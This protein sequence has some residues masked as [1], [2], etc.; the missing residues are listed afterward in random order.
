MVHPPALRALY[1]GLTACGVP[2]GA[3]T[4]ADGSDARTRSQPDALLTAWWTALR[5]VRPQPDAA[6]R[7]GR[8]VPA[9]QFAPLDYLANNGATV[10]VALA[11][12]ERDFALMTDALTLERTTLLDGTVE[13]SVRGPEGYPELAAMSA[14][15]LAGVA[16][17]LAR[18]A[19][20]PLTSSALVVPFRA[21]E[22]VGVPVRNEPGRTCFRVG[23]SDLALSLAGAD[24]A[25]LATLE[26]L[27]EDVVRR[28]APDDPLAAVRS[29]LVEAVQRGEPVDIEATARR[30][31]ASRRTLQRRLAA[32]PVTFSAL[33][34]EVRAEHA[35]RLLGRAELS[36][37]EVADA[38]GFSS[39]SPFA[40]AFKRWT[41]LSP[42]AWRQQAR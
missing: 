41:G 3:L 32:V 5:A 14:F 36:V 37:D 1:E 21:A 31:G 35:I 4:A 24:P 16:S 28:D 12:L 13:L 38:L 11:I 39:S 40:R 9:G 29:L 10:G 2:A 17:R 42:R 23:P 6:V 7:V 33:Y 15:I 18:R 30:L 26:R 27:T 20:R 22:R 19:V 34:D 25:L 8:A